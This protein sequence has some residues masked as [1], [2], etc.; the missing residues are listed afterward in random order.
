M[1]IHAFAVLI[2][3]QGIFSRVVYPGLVIDIV[4]VGLRDLGLDVL[5]GHVSIVAIQAVIFF[6]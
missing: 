6:R 2:V 3:Y 5:G 4:P 1:A